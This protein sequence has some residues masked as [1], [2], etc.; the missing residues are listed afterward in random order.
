MFNDRRVA[1]AVLI[2]VFSAFVPSAGATTIPF[3]FDASLQTGTLSGTQFSGTASYD[4]QGETGVG[5]EFFTLTSLNFS[6]LGFPFTRAD[7]SQGGQA[8]LQ[9]GTLSYFTAA[10][11]PT[12]P[13]SPVTDI[14]FG[15]GG[16]GIIGYV[17]SGENFGSGVYTITPVPEPSTLL[18][19]GIA[20]CCSAFLFLQHRSATRAF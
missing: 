14:A 18:L 16:P 5:T 19:C 9:D 12:S 2:I 20:L 10:F 15:F 4:N 13:S 11:F 1:T 17:T 8:I 6:L 3:T 7:I